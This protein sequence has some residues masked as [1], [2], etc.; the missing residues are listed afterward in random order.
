M[1]DGQPL[2]DH[3]AHRAAHDMGLVDPGRIEHGDGVFGHV[4]Q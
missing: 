2:H 3:A 4:S 1:V